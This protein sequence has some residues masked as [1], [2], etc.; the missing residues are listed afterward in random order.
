MLPMGGDWQM[1]H[2]GHIVVDHNSWF[3]ISVPPP[4]KGAGWVKVGAP[5]IPYPWTSQEG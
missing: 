3:T 5:L 4:A 1:L 2:P